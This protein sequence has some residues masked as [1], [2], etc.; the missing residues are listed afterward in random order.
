MQGRPPGAALLRCSLRRLARSG[1][2]GLV[3]GGSELSQTFR[4]HARLTT[5]IGR[6]CAGPHR[7]AADGERTPL[8]ALGVDQPLTMDDRI[9]TSNEDRPETRAVSER[10]VPPG[11]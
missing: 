8:S 11:K 1:C 6:A 3:E 7:R 9:F 5:L 10:H 4:Y 2:D